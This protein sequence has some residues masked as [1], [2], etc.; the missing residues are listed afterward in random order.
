MNYFIICLLLLTS[1]LNQSITILKIYF[2]FLRGVKVYMKESLRQKCLKAGLNYNTIKNFKQEHPEFTDEQLIEMYKNKLKTK[3]IKQICLE[4][5]VDYNKTLYLKA[6][7]NITIEEAIKL[8]QHNQ[9]IKTFKEKCNEA[10]VNYNKALRCKHTY[11]LSDAEAI[12]FVQQG[13]KKSF[14]AKCR[15]ANV[16]YTRARHIKEKHKCSDEEAIEICKNTRSKEEIQSLKEF[17][18]GM[19]LNYNSTYQNK[20]DKE[21]EE[22]IILRLLKI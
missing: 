22:A 18:A 11:N 20:K 19:G 2:K 7:H 5:G 3:S 13:G 9:T 12:K 15:E 16:D 10:E 17:C 4:Q 6:K 8:Q 21:I 14:A 1:F